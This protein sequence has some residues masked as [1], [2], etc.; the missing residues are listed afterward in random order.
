MS[1]RSQMNQVRAEI[2]ASGDRLI[3]LEAQLSSK[4]ASIWAGRAISYLA[5]AEAAIDDALQ[6]PTDPILDLT[7]G[8]PEPAGA[9]CA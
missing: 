1:N 9:L 3:A 5:L 7:C 4:S 6:F 2:A 8:V